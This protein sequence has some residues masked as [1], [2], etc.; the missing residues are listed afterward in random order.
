MHYGLTISISIL[1][2]NLCIKVFNRVIVI[3]DLCHEDTLFG[4]FMNGLLGCDLS[5][6]FIYYERKYVNRI[7]KFMVNFFVFSPLSLFL[8]RFIDANT[9]I[10]WLWLTRLLSTHCCSL[11]LLF[12]AQFDTTI[13]VCDGWDGIPLATK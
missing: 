13:I 8:Y 4:S 9:Y 1:P 6:I 12:S 5:T 11:F 7:L 2:L 10:E 3:A